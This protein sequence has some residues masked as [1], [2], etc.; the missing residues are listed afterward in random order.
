MNP[1]FVVEREDELYD[2][3]A[4]ASWSIAKGWS[5]RAQVLYLEND[6]NIDLFEYDRTDASLNLRVDF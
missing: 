4:G 6:S 2:V 1:L 5:L 3:V